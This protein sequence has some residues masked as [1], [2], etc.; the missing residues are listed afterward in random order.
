MSGDCGR[1]LRG[2][3]VV[4]ALERIKTERGLIPQRIQTDNGSEFVSKAMDRWAYDHEVIMDY[5]RSGKPTDNPLVE[6]FNGSLRDECLNAHWF[7]SLEDAAQ[8]IEA[9][10]IEYNR[11]RPHSSLGN[12]TPEEFIEAYWSQHPNERSPHS[13]CGSP[14][15][16]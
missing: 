13:A 6:S 3:D 2:Q 5:S 14:S 8:K 1:S 4:E 12:R 16:P 11:Y 10:R 9:W 7:L 15:A